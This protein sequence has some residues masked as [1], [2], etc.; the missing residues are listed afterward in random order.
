M[1]LIL[2]TR[3]IKEQRD[4]WV[5]FMQTQMF[6]WKRQPLLKD[7]SGNFI[8]TGEDEEGNP[9]YKRGKEQ[10][11]RVQGALRPLELW[12]YVFPEE[13]LPEVLAMLNLHQN[14]K[15]RPEIRNWG[16]FLRKMMRLLPLP[17][18]PKEIA[19]KHFQ[20]ITDKFIPMDAM[21][22][23]PIGIKKDYKKDLIFHNGEG[24]Y[25]EGL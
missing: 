4:R 22:V 2:L 15:Q 20:E 16:W 9:T 5:K 25:Q 14:K 12:S 19:D 23:Y 11:M 6:W 10:T 24:W 13:C 8:K 18:M 7:E 3:G 21:A 1:H 17:K